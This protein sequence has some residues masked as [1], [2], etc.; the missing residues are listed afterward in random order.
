[1]VEWRMDN[2]WQLAPDIYTNC[3]INQQFKNEE[4][5]LSAQSYVKEL[6]NFGQ[7]HIEKKYFL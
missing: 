2:T 5:L 3:Y 7:F 4:V 1:M 6:E